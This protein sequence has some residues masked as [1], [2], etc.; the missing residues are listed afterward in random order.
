M[1]QEIFEGIPMRI[2]IGIPVVTDPHVMVRRIKG[3][4]VKRT[5]A[6]R[7]FKKPWTPFQAYKVKIVW[8]EVPGAYLLNP[9]GVDPVIVAHP[10]Y[11][12][13][14]LEGIPSMP[15]YSGWIKNA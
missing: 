14:I 3:A 5:F 13:K 7:L 8:V 6:E 10:L 11:M 12:D 1:M 2:P 9:S 15:V 4:M